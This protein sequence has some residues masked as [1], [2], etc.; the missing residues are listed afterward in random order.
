MA[1]SLPETSD[2]PTP[3]LPAPLLEVPAQESPGPEHTT[4]PVMDVIPSPASQE[5]I[6]SPTTHS[7]TLDTPITPPLMTPILP[8][9]NLT[10]TTPPPP[11]DPG[12]HTILFEHNSSYPN[13]ITMAVIEHLNSVDGGSLWVEMVKSYLVLESKYPSRVSHYF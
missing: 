2:P 5:S 7:P 4:A 10:V 12:T 9:V 1:H 6:P 11:L 13:F 8:P 3:T